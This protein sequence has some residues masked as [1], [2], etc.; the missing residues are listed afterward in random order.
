MELNKEGKVIIKLIN[1]S[2]YEK[3]INYEIQIRDKLINEGNQA[4]LW[5]MISLSIFKE[6]GIFNNYKDKLSFSRKSKDKDDIIGISDTG[7]DILLYNNTDW[8]IVQCKNYTNTIYQDKLSG[9]YQMLLSTKLK[10][11]LYYTSKL[12]HNITRYIQKDIKYINEPYKISL[13]NKPNE[14]SLSNKLVPYDYQI[15]AINKLKQFKRSILSLCC[16]MGKTLCSIYWGD[17][18]DIIIIFAPLKQHCSQNL[19]R[20][21]IELP[22]RKSLIIDSDGTR[23][24]D[25]II[26][27]LFNQDSDSDSSE[28]ECNKFILS[29]TF[30]S[31]DIIEELLN[32]MEENYIN[33]TVGII[34][35]E[36][37]NLTYNDM[38]NCDEDIDDISTPMYNILSNS[39]DNYNFLF[40]SATPKV[41][42]YDEDEADLSEDTYGIFEEITGSFDDAYIYDF[43]KAI[44]NN[45]VTDYEVFIP[46][47]KIANSN[48]TI[49]ECYKYL[50]INEMNLNDLD[51]D[52][53]VQYLLRALDENGHSK[54]ITYLTS[55]DECYKYKESFNKI[56]DYYCM[57]LYIDIIV[58]DISQ[59]NR[60]EILN[61]FRKSTIKSIILSVRI[62]D[63]CIDIPECDSI[64]I[65]N[66]ASSKNKI[67]TIQRICR[68]IRKD[69]NNINKK[70]G[71]YLYTNEYSEISD[72]IINL[73]EY[74][75]TFTVQK[76]K[77]I[78]IQNENNCVKRRENSNIEYIELENYLIGCKRA[79]NWY[80]KL[81]DLKLFININNKRPS[82][83]SKNIIEKKL[84]EW[85]STQI[86]NN[87]SRQYI[88]K[89]EEIY[90]EWIKFI[91]DEKYKKYFL[92]NEEEWYEKLNNLKLFIDINKK[93]PSNKSN[94]CSN[95]K[96]LGMW[97]SHQIDNNKSR[98]DIFKNEEIYNEWTK[99]IND[100]KYKKYFFSNE[101]QWYENLDN[102]K[103]YINVNK[104]R[105][106]ERLK[107]CSNEKQLG[108][109]LSNQITKSK[110]KEQ[111]FKNEK[112]YNEW[113]HFINDEKYKKYFI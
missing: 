51:L 71:I 112:I 55:K 98:K 10:G 26:S 48:N 102:L 78:D 19:E 9:F 93:R 106:N 61:K 14:I 108:Q 83:K 38:V 88:F 47:I 73:K 62:L 86:A 23:N 3:G 76:V 63:E 90:N 37:H 103:S 72:F 111:I 89:N 49:K 35:D 84:G 82:S 99:F 69:K 46:D 22:E 104:K 43:G 27:Y 16:G 105:P 66:P 8:I 96:Q 34:V 5:N 107:K 64:F 110:S 57:D 95:E 12:S 2:N 97:L 85:L 68:S 24:I 77:I 31:A 50:N 7:C 81:N 92:S 87:K 52:S 58:S 20:F 13:V 91:N 36:F 79:S 33:S 59:T 25:E 67:R 45:Y 60:N 75:S 32:Y 30:K 113:T 70:S 80:E 18:F 4:Y 39:N 40:M 42:N 44:T 74:D 94:K 28:S 101:K 1:E 109:W 15:E 100:E 11:E 41:Y 29:V 17:R 65:P 56:K 21:K 6:S 54:C 53:K